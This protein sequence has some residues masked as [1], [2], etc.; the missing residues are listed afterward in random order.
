M[1]C[2]STAA[3][4]LS[5]VHNACPRYF[6]CCLSQNIANAA[7]QLLLRLLMSQP[8]LLISNCLKSEDAIKFAKLDSW[9][10]WSGDSTV[11]VNRV[12]HNYYKLQDENLR[13][14]RAAAIQRCATVYSKR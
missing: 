4:S 10:E 8:T 14:S 1:S 13:H 7:T 2:D 12:T 3:A 6:S 9:Y 5:N 11:T